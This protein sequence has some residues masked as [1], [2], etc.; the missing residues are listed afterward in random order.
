MNLEEIIQRAVLCKATDIHLELHKKP[1]FRYEKFLNAS[2]YEDM[3]EVQPAVFEELFSLANNSHE[4]TVV[5]SLDFS[6]NRAEH[7]LRGHIYRANGNW[8]AALRLLPSHE[9]KLEDDVDFAL[10]SKL[11]LLRDGL[12]LLTGPTGSGKTYTLGGCIEFINKQRECHLITLEDPIEIVFSS[13]R[14]LVHQRQ[15][16]RDFS[17]MADGLRDA[18]REDPDVIMIGEMRDRE[19]IEAALHAAET[20]HL[21]L[22]TLHTNNARQAVQRILSYFPGERRDE[23]RS[24]MADV[25]R[26]VICQRLLRH[27]GKF[28]QVRDIMLNIKSVANLIRQGK[29]HQILSIQETTAEMQTFEKAIQK[30]K[31]TYGTWADLHELELSLVN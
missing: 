23:I 29:E 24:M 9:I 7:D 8:C 27:E 4:S 6:F 19:T 28:L 14:A 21:V 18:M 17:T 1:Y 25:L 22:A 5:N 15:L 31:R 2:N 16:G 10:W 3:E 30:I 12:V 13:K 11:C 26:A 20:G